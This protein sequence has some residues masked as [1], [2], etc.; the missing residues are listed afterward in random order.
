[1][2]NIQCRTIVDQVEI[3]R[4]GAV[5]VRLAK[6]IVDGDKLLAS[7]WHRMSV[8]PGDD[9]DLQ[10]SYVCANLTHLGAGVP[11]TDEWAR[12]RRV[13]ATEHTP[14]VIAAFAK[15]Q[16]AAVAALAPSTAAVPASPAPDHRD[17]KAAK[18]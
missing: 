7:A 9:L 8:N 14:D 18:K 12:V 10:I 3:G 4:D 16:S 2:S 15:A 11:K 17:E 5:L 1:M 6:Q 13:V